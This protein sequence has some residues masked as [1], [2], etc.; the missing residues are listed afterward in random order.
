MLKDSIS[1]WS[2]PGHRLLRV[3]KSLSTIFFKIMIS[4]QLTDLCLT[5]CQRLSVHHRCNSW[6]KFFSCGLLL[7]FAMFVNHLL[8]FSCISVFHFPFRNSCS[9]E[10]S[11]NT[12]HDQRQTKAFFAQLIF[13]LHLWG[14]KKCNWNDTSELCLLAL[15]YKKGMSRVW[16]KVEKE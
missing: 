6:A 5:M 1:D 15:L 8:V 12:V 11:W 2:K 13:S 4:K 9:Q 3:S 10:D 14:K 16:S 7:G